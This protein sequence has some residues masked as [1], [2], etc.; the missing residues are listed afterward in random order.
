[1][2]VTATQGTVQIGG[3]EIPDG[4]YATA[5][6]GTVTAVEVTTVSVSGLYSTATRGTIGVTSPSWGNFTWG[7]DT[8]GQ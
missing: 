8:W 1:M 4:L 5:T 7:H 2:Y 6:Q 3:I